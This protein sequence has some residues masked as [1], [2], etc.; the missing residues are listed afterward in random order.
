M[1][2]FLKYHGIDSL[3]LLLLRCKLLLFKKNTPIIVFT[4]AKVG[5]LSV[6]FSLKKSL[7]T[8]TIFHVHSLNENEIKKGIQLCFDQGIYPG[9]K[10][11]VSLINSQILSKKKPFKIVCLF[12]DPLE[13]NISAFFDAFELHTGIKAE[14]YDGSLEELK[15]NFYNKLNH[16]YPLQ[17]FEN[18]FKEATG[19]DLYSSE[20]DTEKGYKIL[21]SNKVE[22][23]L[24]NSAISDSKKEELIGDF[25]NVNNFKLE[26]RNQS[27]QK[28]YAS[29]YS[30]FKNEIRFSSTYLHQI[31]SSNY[32]KHF[33]SNSHIENQIKKWSE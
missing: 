5:S 6:Y 4:M 13:R 19:L 16:K 30:N 14:E 23:I 2:Q 15:Q 18:Q 8:T 32:A 28:E 29:L 24:L 21:Q 1:K 9:S 10:S 27:H 33:F 17:W 25:C 31:Y 20:F 22:V 26:N 12:R 3:R 11:P 7:P